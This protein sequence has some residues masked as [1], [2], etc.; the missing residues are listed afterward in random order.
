M[1]G[2]EDQK[3]VYYRV[4]GTVISCPKDS[5]EDKL[6]AKQ[7]H[8]EVADAEGTPITKVVAE[9]KKPKARKT[10]ETA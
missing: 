6:R 7:G 1:S 9:P 3:I 8:R 10:V 2:Q 4:S 5:W